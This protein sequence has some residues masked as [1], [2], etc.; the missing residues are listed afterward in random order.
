MRRLAIAL[1]AL[2]AAGAAALWVGGLDRGSRNGTSIKR[3]ATDDAPAG[4]PLSSPRIAAT[5]LPPDGTRS[6]FDHLV[7]Q[8]DGLPYP[9]E[10]LVGMIQRQA[11]A[12]AAPVLLS[13]PFGRSLLK[14]QADFGHPRVLFAADFQAPGTPAALGLAARGRLFLGFVENARE[15]EVISY[16]E[17]AGRYE[18]QLVQDYAADGARRIVYA[19]RAVCTTCHQG[20]TPIF[21]Q[22]PWT[23]TNAQPE[24]AAR[25]AAARGTGAYLGVPA[26]VALGLPERFDEL[27]DIGAFTIALQ[28]MWIDGCGAD[29]GCRRLMLR[30][31]LRYANDPGAFGASTPEVAVL[32]ERQRAHWPDAGIAVPESDLRNRDPLADTQGLR[33]AWHRVF[34]PRAG[35]ADGARTNEDLAAFDRLPKLPPELD[36][37]TRRAPK[38]VLRADDL[39]GVFGIAAQ[40]TA[41]DLRRLEAQDGH[42]W[43]RVEARIEGLPD[44]FFE[45]APFS[46]VR[47]MQALLTPAPQYCCLDVTEMSAPVAI[48][49]PPLAL[50][51][52]SPLHAFER[53]CFGC[54]RGNPSA[55]LDFMAGADE[56]EVVR[57]IR[58]KAEIRDALDWSR[59][60]GTDRASRL[61]PPAD[62]PERARLEEELAHNPRLLEQMRAQVPALFE[63]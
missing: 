25:I 47:V 49:V 34:A 16:N 57:N 37:L 9:F 7:A 44:A 63:F 35:A 42:D 10:A 26:Q 29:A 43:S 40:F 39:D 14:A 28:Q 59:Y 61:M 36:P 56:A 4:A 13:I 1:V 18:F 60:R 53:Y 32:R 58:A 19:R 17:A 2:A 21:P 20:G 48:G 31:G 3:L 46:R 62:S 50:A 5:D 38:R 27:T 41:D 30:L 24:I 6:L 51:A 55:R 54:H 15:I 33:G 45:P 23:E 8:N 11:P 22:R 52:D 12:D